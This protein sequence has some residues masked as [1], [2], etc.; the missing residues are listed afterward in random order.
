MGSRG[1]LEGVSRGIAIARA[2]QGNAGSPRS[3]RSHGAAALWF[4]TAPPPAAPPSPARARD[5]SAT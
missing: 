1:D 3:A 5:S 4:G 2:A